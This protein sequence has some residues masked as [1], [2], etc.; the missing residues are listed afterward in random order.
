MSMLALV[1]LLLGQC[2]LAAHET[3][4]SQHAPGSHC[5]WCIAAAPLHAALG[6]DAPVLPLVSAAR[7]A[8]VT[9]APRAVRSFHTSVYF[10]RAPPLFSC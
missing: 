9:H 1:L 6:A 10:G 4:Q 7:H 8:H 2:A 3:D 5:E